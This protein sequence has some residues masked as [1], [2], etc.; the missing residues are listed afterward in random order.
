MSGGGWNGR[1]GHT[2]RPR[3]LRA[4]SAAAA[5]TTSDPF[6]GVKSSALSAD[7][8][9]QASLPTVSGRMPAAGAAGAAAAAAAEAAREWCR[10]GRRG[11][12]TRQTGKAAT[13]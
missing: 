1:P 7:E 11:S 2:E 13:D 5:A 3:D 9:L 6:V 12:G 8:S 10:Y 4:P